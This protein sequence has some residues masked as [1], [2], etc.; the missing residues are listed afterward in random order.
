MMLF[1]GCCAVERRASG[2]RVEAQRLR[3]RVRDVETLSHDPG[4]EATRRAELRHFLEEVVVRVEEEGEALAELVGRQAGSDGRLRVRDAVRERERELLNGGRAGLA[5]VVAGD[6]DRVPL[7]NVL[8]GVGEQIRRDPH[9]RARREDVVPARDVLLEDVVLHGAAQ[10]RPRHTLLFRDELVQQEQQRSRCVDRH[11]RRD[12]AERD[13]VEEQLHVG[14]RV[15]RDT[16][17][18][19][20]ADG[21]RI[22]RVVAELRRQVE[23]DRQAGLSSFEQIAEALVRLFCGGEPGVLPDRPRAAAVHVR[24]RAARERELAGKLERSPSVL[25]RVDR[26]QL[27]A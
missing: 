25:S 10:L 6:R 27:D 11:R 8:G 18:A 24:V 12:L 1:S 15:D 7:R 13:P 21:A 20:L 17:P 22:V 9:R 19:D 2:L 14:D 5:D 4:P 23:R 26:L 16:G 3:L